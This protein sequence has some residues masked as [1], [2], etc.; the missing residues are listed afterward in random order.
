MTR[1]TQAQK[2]KGPS[3]GS[4]GHLGVHLG[5]SRKEQPVRCNLLSLLLTHSLGGFVIPPGFPLF[6]HYPVLDT[7]HPVRDLVVQ[8]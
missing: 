1:Q 6:P 3:L 4:L 8:R 5:G 2:S 7:V